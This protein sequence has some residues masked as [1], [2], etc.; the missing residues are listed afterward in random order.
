MVQITAIAN[1]VQ[2]QLQ[3]GAQMT[4]F[5]QVPPLDIV[6]HFQSFEILAGTMRYAIVRG[7]SRPDMQHYHFNDEISLP[8]FAI[9]HYIL[10]PL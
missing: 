2:G 3:D 5:L 10:D 8:I 1:I 6:N 9:P 7:I 4:P